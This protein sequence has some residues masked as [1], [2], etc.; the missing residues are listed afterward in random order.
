MNGVQSHLL[1]FLLRWILEPLRRLQR[2]DW[3]WLLSLECYTDQFDF[4]NSVS[5]FF[6]DIIF[7]TEKNDIMIYKLALLL[8]SSA[9]KS[10]NYCWIIWWVADFFW[11]ENIF[12]LNW[13]FTRISLLS[14]PFKL[15]F[16]AFNFCF[17]WSSVRIVILEWL[18]PRKF[19]PIFLIQCC[20]SQFCPT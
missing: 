8:V 13:S 14:R 7:G 4:S 6:F 15:K 5:M 12:E 9:G 19:S 10:S 18:I 1:P 2:L 20:I 16:P 11:D 17:W 3:L